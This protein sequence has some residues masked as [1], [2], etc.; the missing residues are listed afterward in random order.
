[1]AAAELAPLSPRRRIVESTEA[2][3][4]AATKLILDFSCDSW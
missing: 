3:T 2:A 4:D 1:M